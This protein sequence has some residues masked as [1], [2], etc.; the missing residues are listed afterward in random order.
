M[1]K[2]ILTMDG[3]EAMQEDRNNCNQEEMLDVAI[4]LIALDSDMQSS[5]AST[6]LSS[7]DSD[8]DS[9]RPLVPR[10]LDPENTD[11]DLLQRD[12]MH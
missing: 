9:D 3:L 4:G 6:S 11:I 7:P 5:G 12:L 8:S 10:P 1:Y 2:I